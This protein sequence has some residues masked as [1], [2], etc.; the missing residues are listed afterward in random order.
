MTRDC[1]TSRMS[2]FDLKDLIDAT[3]SP[4]RQMVTI[5]MPAIRVQELNAV[6]EAVSFA[7]GTPPDPIDASDEITRRLE[8]ASARARG[9]R[10]PGDVTLIGVICTLSMIVCGALASLG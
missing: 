8:T 1:S 10:G 5:R 9:S 2:R 3:A 7:E 6:P 4:A